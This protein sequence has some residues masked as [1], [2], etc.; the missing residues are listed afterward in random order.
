MA[1]FICI[2]SIADA[3]QVHFVC[4]NRAFLLLEV[5][6]ILV[7]KINSQNRVQ[8]NFLLFLSLEELA[9]QQQLSEI[10]HIL[11]IKTSKIYHFNILIN[12]VLILK[13]QFHHAQTISVQTYGQRM[14]MFSTQNIFF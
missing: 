7:R 3:W 5:L 6:G 11:V 13:I 4:E 8:C 1:H 2:H 14:L 9:L 12:G 10:N